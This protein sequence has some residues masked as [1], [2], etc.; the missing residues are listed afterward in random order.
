MKRPSAWIGI[1]L[2]LAGCKMGPAYQRPAAAVPGAYRDAPTE[3]GGKPLSDMPWWEVFQDATLKALV[4]EA[5]RSN[6]DLKVAL[7]RVEQAR[8]FIGVSRADLYPRVDGQA[9]VTRS[10]TSRFLAETGDRTQTNYSAAI[11]AT[12]EIDV[13]GRIRNGEDAAI[14]DWLATE[15]GRRAV[16][17][18]L[19]GDVSTAYFTLRELDLEL[20]IA[21]DNTEARGKS[22]DLFTKRLEGGVSSKLEVA[23]AAGDVAATAATI[24]V[25]QRDIARTENLINFLLGRNPGPISRPPL[26]KDLPLPPDVPP[27]IP[28][29]LLERRPDILEAEQRM[30]AANARVGVATSNLYPTFSLTGILGLESRQLSDLVK[31]DAVAWSLG[32][33]LI[34]PIFHG[35]KL[36]AER[37]VAIGQWEETKASYLKIVQGAFVEVADGLISR[38]KTREARIELEKQV[39]ARKEALDLAWTRFNGG[40]ASYFEVLDSQRDLFP[41]EIQLAEARL[42]EYLSVVFLYRALGGGWIFAEGIGAPCVRPPS[43][44]TQPTTVYYGPPPSSGTYPSSGTQAPS[45]PPALP[46]AMPSGAATSPPAGPPPAPPSSGPPPAPA[47]V[48]PK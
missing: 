15:D 4:D 11:G 5:V 27:G 3:R 28:S 10:Q 26:P 45:Q 42:A 2:L 7:A 41:A 8:A 33:G 29:T 35:G 47:P 36:R 14:A 20:R 18:T 23:R 16:L 46:P 1:A 37:E 48:S 17:V 43:S 22:L 13:F 21:I 6:W 30:I 12:W 39:G 9:G 19:V 34:A 38:T 31:S 40:L 44:A 24:P 25:I 32:A